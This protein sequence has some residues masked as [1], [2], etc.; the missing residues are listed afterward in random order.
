MRFIFQLFWFCCLFELYMFSFVFIAK[1]K[2]LAYISSCTEFGECFSCYACFLCYMRTALLHMS[3]SLRIRAELV[4]VREPWTSLLT[5]LNM[6]RLGVLGH[7][8]DKNGRNYIVGSDYPGYNEPVG[9]GLGVT[10]SEWS[11]AKKPK[12]CRIKAV[13]LELK[14]LMVYANSIQ[15]HQNLQKMVC[16]LKI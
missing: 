7:H 12:D 4:R 1:K 14:Q 15:L 8:Q 2:M 13:G 6:G 16:L 9:E 3:S 11:S 5:G 10:N